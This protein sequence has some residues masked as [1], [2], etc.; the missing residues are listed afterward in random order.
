GDPHVR[1][2]SFLVERTVF[3]A[4]LGAGKPA[5]A[6]AVI[7][8]ILSRSGKPPGVADELTAGTMSARLKASSKK[9]ADQAA[10]IAELTALWARAAKAGFVFHALEADLAR[11]KLER[12]AGRAPAAR[13]TLSKVQRDASQLGLGRMAAEAEKALQEG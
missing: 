9:P 13:T 8:R 5:E 4:E 12:A 1:T 6:K 3:D 10:A 7:D 2:N 11:G